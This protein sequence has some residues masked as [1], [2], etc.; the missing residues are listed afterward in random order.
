MEKDEVPWPTLERIRA[1]KTSG[2]ND[3]AEQEIRRELER[4]PDHLL[5]K[6]SLA[7]LYLRQ[8]RLPEGRILA[9][10]ILARDPQHPQGLAIM[11]DILLKQ[12]LSREALECYR[13]ASNRDPRPY[14]V[15]KVVRAL[16]E[17]GDT[18]EA[19]QELERVLVRNPENVP[20]LKE[21]AV[22]LNRLKRYDEAL[23]IYEKLR[24]L[25]PADSF[26][27]KE[28]LRLRGRDR[29]QEQVLTDLQKVMGMDS[30]R[31]DAQ[32]HGL[33]AEK[34]KGAGQVREAAVEYGA[35]AQL[36]PN[37]LYFV[38]QQGFC[39]YRLKKYGETI[40][41]L[42]EVF[43]KDPSD[44]FVRSALEKSFEAEGDLKGL[45]HL[46]EETLHLHPDQKSLL[47]KIKKMRKRLDADPVE[48]A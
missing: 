33:L 14:L 35:A 9:E 10:E 5:L 18:S 20:F 41:S 4:N 2:K 46:L 16:K 44:F 1:L 45:L 22:I 8:G 24:M 39:F 23:E 43:K 27:Q 42:S 3:E 38:K 47:G 6:A 37:N 28:I 48:K 29:P 30:R 34:L 19:L 12:R 7:D 36:E 21:K 11:G 15:L 31:D 13:Q 17:T 26:V 25:A 40:R 32:M